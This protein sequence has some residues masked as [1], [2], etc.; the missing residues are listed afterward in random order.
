M[1][2]GFV[3]LAG[4]RV[5]TLALQLIAFGVVAACLRS[6]TDTAPQSALVAPYSCM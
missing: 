3:A 5:A 4:G 6:A 1:T 2:R